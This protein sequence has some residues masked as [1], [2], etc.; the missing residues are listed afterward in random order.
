MERFK[1]SIGLD[2]KAE[3][4]FENCICCGKLTDVRKD[5]PVDVRKYHID[6]AGQSCEECYEEIYGP[7]PLEITRERIRLNTLGVLI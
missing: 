6:G 5:T 3:M 7:L 4:N 1:V 2:N